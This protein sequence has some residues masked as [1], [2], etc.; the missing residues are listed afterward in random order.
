MGRTGSCSR[1]KRVARKVV[2]LTDVFEDVISSVR[3]EGF[4]QL[5]RGCF[6]DFVVV[7][8]VT[9]VFVS[10]GHLDQREELVRVSL[11]DNCLNFF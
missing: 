10:V 1:C 7:R 3:V 8:G 4:E 6:D 11:V 2:G 5:D 9:R